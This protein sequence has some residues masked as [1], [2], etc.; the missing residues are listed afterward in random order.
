MF[1]V[2]DEFNGLVWVHTIGQ[3]A[4]LDIFLNNGD[5]VPVEI[6]QENGDLMFTY[7]YP[8]LRRVI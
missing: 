5:V 7:I 1:W 4:L 8:A 2:I 3:F 6:R